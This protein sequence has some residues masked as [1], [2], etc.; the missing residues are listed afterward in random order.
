MINQLFSRLPPDRFVP[1]SPLDRK[2]RGP[3][4]CFQARSPEKTRHYYEKLR[5]E[6]VIVSLRE[7]RIRVSPYV[8]NN[9]RDIDRLISVVAI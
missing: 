3:Y 1:A 4:G 2:L 6:N 5:A 8:Y 9:A 7:N